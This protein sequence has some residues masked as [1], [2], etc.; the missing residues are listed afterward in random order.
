[1]PAG[2]SAVEGSFGRGDPVTIRGLNGETLGQ[3]LTRYTASEARA[4][5]GRRSSEIESILQFV[6]RAVELER[7][8][9]QAAVGLEQALSDVF[10]LRRFRAKDASA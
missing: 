10:S 6:L 8:E 2:L 7:Q 5:A 9:R 1:M 4:I 3:G